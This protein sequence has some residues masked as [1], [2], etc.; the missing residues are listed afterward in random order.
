MTCSLC[1]PAQGD[2]SSTL[3]TGGQEDR[4]PSPPAP[5]LGVCVGGSSGIPHPTAHPSPTLQLYSRQGR[6]RE[7]SSPLQPGLLGGW[8]I[9]TRGGRQR[10]PNPDGP[11][12]TCS[13]G[14][15]SRPGGASPEDGGLPSPP[16]IPPWGCGG[17]L[18]STPSLGAVTQRSQSGGELVLKTESSP[19]LPEGNGFIWARGC[20]S[21]L[22][23][24]VGTSGM[25][26]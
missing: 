15:S 23:K 11:S 2:G 6:P 7:P 12:P 13:N 20:Q 26:N 25:R 3:G 14:R 19:A 16:S 24:T 18:S 21:T 22:L 9:C 10:V 5:T 1:L 17:L 4:A 8:A